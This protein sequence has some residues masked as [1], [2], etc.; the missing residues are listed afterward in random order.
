M[1]CITKIVKERYE[2]PVP[3]Y[4][5]HVKEWTSYFVC[6]GGGIRVYVHNGKTKTHGNVK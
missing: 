6:G 5:F 3:V 4:N 2:E 1:A